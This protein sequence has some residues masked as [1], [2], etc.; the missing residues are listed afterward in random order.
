MPDG[1]APDGPAP[2][3]AGELT[4]QQ[5]R[6]LLDLQ[7]LRARAMCGRHLATLDEML[8]DALI[9]VHANG[10]TDDKTGFLALIEHPVRRYL[11]IDYADCRVVGLGEGGRVVAGRALLRL[12]R[13]GG[14]HAELPVRYTTVYVRRG[15]T[16]RLVA[17]Q[18]TSLPD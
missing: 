12:I 6:E 9:Y 3:A 8:D 4:P 5:Q 2:T 17:W 18:A 14:E 10:A 11:S 16:W 13:A 7:E 15:A 1:P